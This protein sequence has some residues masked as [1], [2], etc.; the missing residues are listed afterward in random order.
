[1]LKA[2]PKRSTVIK[3]Q[4]DSL[5]K[6]L[7]KIQLEEKRKEIPKEIWKELDNLYN[8]IFDGTGSVSVLLKSVEVSFGFEIVSNKIR[9]YGIEVSRNWQKIP[10]ISK[11]INTY[12][13]KVNL[14]LKRVKEINK[15]YGVNID[16][17]G[18]RC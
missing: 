12:Q 3:A 4:I 11:E 17:W 18:Q 8:S 1:M 6:E 10:E 16:P 15:K 5:K 9:P 13:N 14:Y 2:R 7:H